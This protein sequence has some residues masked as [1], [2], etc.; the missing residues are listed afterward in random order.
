[1]ALLNDIKAVSQFTITGNNATTN[2]VAVVAEM[3]IKNYLKNN[4]ATLGLRA[5]MTAES[6][7]TIAGVGTAI[8]RLTKRAK[9]GHSYDFEQ[10]ST[11]KQ[12]SGG[13][14][15][16]V[17]LNQETDATLMFESFD[18]TRY[19]NGGEKHISQSIQSLY[20]AH[21]ITNELVYMRGVIDYCLAKGQYSVLPMK[22]IANADD[23]NTAYFTIANKVLE[24]TDKID[25]VSIG[26]NKE[27]FSFAV[28]RRA[29]LGLVKAHIKDS[30]TETTHSV[31]ATGELYQ[32]KILGTYVQESFWLDKKVEKGSIDLDIEYDLENVAGILVHN[33]AVANPFA[34]EYN[35]I[36]EDNYTAN[37]KL[38]LKALGSLPVVMRPELLH[39]F[40]ETK[41]DDTRIQKAKDAVY[42]GNSF[43]YEK[44]YKL[45]E[46][47]KL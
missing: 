47:D 32:N 2:D 23:A 3:Q 5:S 17:F 11:T 16:L 34:Y 8:Y 45:A 18:T 36:L 28:S 25:D 1:M 14:N 4:A 24:L 26:T 31:L 22:T 46:F 39:I 27:D 38:I 33:D 41:P 29:H 21:L 43:R 12:R 7:S 9:V 37:L 10:G 15:A 44:S 13:K 42:D 6:I 35:K 20:D 19:S 30:G 40:L